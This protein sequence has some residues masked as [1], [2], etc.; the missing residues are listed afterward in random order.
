[1]DEF[2]GEWGKFRDEFEKFGRSIDT[3]RTGY[4][5]ITSTRTKQLERKIEKIDN[6]RQGSGDLLGDKKAK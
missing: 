6:Y 4:E 5:K 1:I 2:V 3:L